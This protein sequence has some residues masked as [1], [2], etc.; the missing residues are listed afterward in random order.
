[1]LLSLAFLAVCTAL[2]EG[3]RP[4]RGPGERLLRLLVFAAGAVLPLLALPDI[5]EA[6]EEG[7]RFLGKDDDWAAHNPEQT[8]LFASVPLSGV[9]PPTIRFGFFAYW[10]P[11]TPLAVAVLSL[12]VRDEVRERM[13][14]FVCWITALC[15]LVLSQVR[16]GTDFAVPGAVAFALMLAAVRATVARRLPRQIAAATAIGLAVVMLWP[17][18][19]WHAPVVKRSL[20]QRLTGEREAPR[21]LL[22]AR[23]S[24]F[25]WAEMLRKMTPE[26]SGYLTPD[27]RPE[28][29]ILVHPTMGH[30]V[31]YTARRPAPAN[32]LGPYL[33]RELYSLATS[34]YGASDALRGLRILEQLGTRYVVT[35]WI[36]SPP[37]SF[38]F[39][40]HRTNGSA[41][42]E[43]SPT[44]RLRLLAQGPR[45]GRPISSRPGPVPGPVYKL[46]ERV[47]GAILV[48]TGAEPSTRV[49][50]AIRLTTPAGEQ[51]YR[52]LGRAAADGVARVR[53]PYPSDS[54][55]VREGEVGTLG[56]WIVRVGE[57]SFEVEVTEKDVAEGREVRVGG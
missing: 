51:G 10:I 20:T 28:Y 36:W 53:V 9:R 15:V 11:V 21:G 42:P 29:A 57:Q 54:R 5:R 6:L 52:A 38:A 56:S 48:V 13:F 14:V 43:R 39:D 18:W 50:A 27:E 47:E 19:Q 40:L 37:G 1:V 33:D 8:A 4:A 26:T 2:I 35:G 24:A 31:A 46:F 7:L 12:R 23:E 3:L 34:F 55:P 22:S 17:V 25:R 16:Y 30:L 41:E 49:R 45:G 32:N 44:G